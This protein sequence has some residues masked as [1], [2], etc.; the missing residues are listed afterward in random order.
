M[1]YRLL[2]AFAFAARYEAPFTAADVDVRELIDI[3]LRAVEA[4][5]HQA[6]GLAVPTW[7]LP[8]LG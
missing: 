4:A 2:R 5:V 7:Q 8:E 6:L 3:D 1:S